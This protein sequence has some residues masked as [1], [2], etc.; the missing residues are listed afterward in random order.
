MATVPPQN[1]ICHCFLFPPFYLPWSDGQDAIILI[2]WCWVLSQLAH[3]PLSPSFWGEKRGGLFSSFSLSAIRVVPAA[4]LRLLI[5]LPAI[6]TPACDSSSPGFCPMHSAYKI[7]TGWWYT[8]LFYSFS[9]L[10]LVSCSMFGSNCCYLTHIQVSQ[11]TGEVVLYSHFFKNF[12]H[13]VVIHT[14][15]GFSVVDEAEVRCF[16]G[17]PLLS[18]WSNKCWQ[19]DQEC[20]LSIS[21]SNIP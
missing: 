1:K 16:T 21:I 19:F 2:F 12:P 17:I 18:L 9:N 11:K 8:A 3:S 6:L 10:E 4:C 20:G 15:K 5:F 14:V 13:F 7:S